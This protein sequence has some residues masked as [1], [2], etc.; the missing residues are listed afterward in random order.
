[1]AA[2][3]TPDGK[4]HLLHET[5]SEPAAA[6]YAAFG[7][8]YFG[9]VGRNGGVA[10]NAYELFCGMMEIYADF[11]R[12]QLAR[13]LGLAPGDPKLAHLNDNELREH[14]A[15]RIAVSADTRKPL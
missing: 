1:M 8:S 10:K 4:S 3:T 5:M 11:N 9:E 14:I 6:D 12:E 7:E 2:V 13:Q 15:E